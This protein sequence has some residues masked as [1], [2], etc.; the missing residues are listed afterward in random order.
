MLNDNQRNTEGNDN[1]NAYHQRR[2][3]FLI[4]IVDEQRFPPSYENAQMKDWRLKNLKAQKFLRSNG[5]EFFN[6]YAA[7]T[8]CSPSRTSLYTGQYPSLHGVTQTD[9][10][11]DTAFD[12]NV[13]WLDPNTVPTFG[14]Y[15]RTVGYD[16]YWRGKWH[17]SHSDIVVPG[18][19]ESLLSYENETGIPD[20]EKERIYREANR[21]EE[22]GF[23]GWIGPEPH[24][25][26]PHNSG[27][28]AA[29]GLSGRDVIY[30]EE[31]VELLQKLQLKKEQL[32]EEEYNPWAIVASF[33]NPHDIALFGAFT[34]LLP[35]FHFEI[36]D[37][38]P[39][40]PPS[41]TSQEN[42]DTKPEAQASYRSTY[43]KMIQP[44]ADTES[45]RSLY[46]SLQLEVDKEVEKVL[47]ELIKTDFYDNTI[48]IYTSD[49]GDLLG[50][51]GGLFQ[52]W[53]QAY[54]EAIHV[55]LI[56]H[57][58]I[59]VPRRKAVYNLTSHVDILPTLLNLAGID[60]ISSLELLKKSHSEVHPL[61]GQNLVPLI[62]ES[63]SY[64]LEEPIYFMTDDDPSKT[65]N[66]TT[67]NRY[68]PVT[69]PNHIETVVVKL[70]T[71][72]DNKLEIWK[73][74][75]YFDNTQ[76][77]TTP[78]VEN[79]STNEEYTTTLAGD[80]YCS[81]NV[82]KVKTHPVPD[83]IEMYNLTTD[84]IE[85]KNLA[86]ALYTTV[87]TTVIQAILNKILAEQ[88]EKK[89]LYPTSGNAAVNSPNQKNSG[90]LFKN[91]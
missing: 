77:W 68:E 78:E 45:Y 91:L 3:N 32:K 38:V 20:L 71:G 42:L 64:Y 40:V 1:E 19:H 60:P 90:N 84:P 55:P 75:R 17:A 43:P 85:S 5:V 66:T 56:I 65:L 70:P 46:Y 15:L 57:N 49:H 52:K 14:D 22:Y 53:Y 9:G 29:K 33:V 31:L 39:T 63:E 62:K 34:R 36:N 72:E 21:L 2:P 41:P 61:V 87:E 47:N 44:L 82:T 81:L 18:T 83:E 4:I 51:H 27:S 54:E 12:P 73:Y 23:D 69:Q 74:S 8:A 58:P 26:N 25:T 89:R 6:H 86:N 79:T 10:G 24:G 50:S 67:G 16:T 80:T 28:S 88:S 13:F 11:G 37:S 48:I 35:T 7:S 59:L 30:T 76:F